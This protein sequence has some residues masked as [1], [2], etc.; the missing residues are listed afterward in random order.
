MV[1]CVVGYLALC[2]VVAQCYYISS[3][4]ISWAIYI[5]GGE[6]FALFC[7]PLY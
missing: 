4:D 1:G 2:L 6:K 7:R 3:V 5:A